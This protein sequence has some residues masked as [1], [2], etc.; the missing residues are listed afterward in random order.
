MNYSTLIIFTSFIIYCRAYSY[1]YT[2]IR[3]EYL[4]YFNEHVDIFIP[5]PSLFS[6]GYN[7]IF[8]IK[9]YY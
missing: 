6:L 4:A 7:F 9:N 2:H 5:S 1:T 8:F 3:D